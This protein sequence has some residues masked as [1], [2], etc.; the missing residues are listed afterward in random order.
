[1][2]RSTV[3]ANAKATAGTIV[4]ASVKASASIKMRTR[5]MPY[6][7]IG[8]RFSTSLNTSIFSRA[9]AGRRS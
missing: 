3:K 2:A 6:L 4:R 5:A 9:S 8:T 7:N 1:M